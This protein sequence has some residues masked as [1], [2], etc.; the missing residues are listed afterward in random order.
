MNLKLITAVAVVLQTAALG[1]LA[2]ESTRP[3]DTQSTDHSMHD[4]YMS[5]D[6][7]SMDRMP[8]DT[9]AFVQ[10]AAVTDMAEIQ[11]GQLALQK[12]QDPEIRK[13]AERMV[14]DHTASSAK[15]KAAAAKDN[16]TVP[17][18]LD[19]K[20]QQTVQE[21]QALNGEA[22]DTAYRKH[23]GKGHHKAVELFENASKS[24]QVAEPVR[25]FAAST[26][27]TIKAHYEMADDLDDKATAK[28]DYKSDRE[29]RTATDR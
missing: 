28:S 18:A 16:V 24:A 11:L 14:K 7:S 1:A 4:K 20:H 10:K 8:V 2:Q 23:M 12:S 29:D 26:L 21:L 3:A 17:T 15:L 13:F 6:K 22:F 27:P 5:K 9:Q 19:A 25:Q